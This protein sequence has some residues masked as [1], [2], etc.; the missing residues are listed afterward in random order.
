MN[1]NGRKRHASRRSVMTIRPPQANSA[2]ADASYSGSRVLA[3]NGRKYVQNDGDRRT[4]TL[5]LS[6]LQPAAMPTQ[7]T[8]DPFLPRQIQPLTIRWAHG[9]WGLWWR[10]RRCSKMLLDIVVKRVA[11]DWTNYRYQCHFVDAPHDRTY[12]YR[13]LSLQTMQLIFVFVCA[14]I[15]P[16][17]GC[18]FSYIV[19]K[20]VH[21]DAAHLLPA[22]SN[23][24]P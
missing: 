13:M 22:A 23:S 15:H 14:H 2:E 1:V 8:P 9:G 19:E 21:F 20:T 24:E 7:T 10:R 11:G 12:S 6:A 5:G 16:Q 4:R 3:D 18:S 17:I